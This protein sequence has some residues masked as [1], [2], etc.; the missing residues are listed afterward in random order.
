MATELTDHITDPD[1]KQGA[2]QMYG[3]MRT[4]QAE[5]IGRIIVNVVT[6][7]AHVAINEILVRPTDQ[8]R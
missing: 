1:S 8:A 6:Q 2:E 3:S 5:D 7:P 4:L